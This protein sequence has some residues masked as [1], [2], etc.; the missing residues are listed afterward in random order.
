VHEKGGRRGQ[1]RDLGTIS[2]CEINNL[3]KEFL[4]MLREREE[5]R[6]TERQRER[7][8]EGDNVEEK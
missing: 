7:E 5:D 2:L 3:V 8:R 4:F 1:G 6:D